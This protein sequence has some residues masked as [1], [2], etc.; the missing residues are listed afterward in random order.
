M[1]LL[2]KELDKFT[3]ITKIVINL[4]T[5]HKLDNTCFTFESISKSNLLK[6]PKAT[7]Y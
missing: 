6:Y 4:I 3:V 1:R 2:F 5:Y 7:N